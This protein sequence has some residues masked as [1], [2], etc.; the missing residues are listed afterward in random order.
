MQ[1]GCQSHDIEQW[2]KFT[3]KEIGNMECGALEWWN[4]WKDIIKNIIDIS[5]CEPTKSK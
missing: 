1:I 2:F 5:P 4:K 3:D